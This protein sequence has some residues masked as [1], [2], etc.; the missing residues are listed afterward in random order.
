M[1]QEDFV[2]REHQKQVLDICKVQKRYG[3]FF[4]MGAGKTSTM[5]SLIDYL[6][7]ESME[8][9]KIL[10]IA[11]STVINKAKVW[12]KEIKKW[13]NFHFFDFIELNGSPDDRIKKKETSLN[14]I[15][16]MSDG[17]VSWYKNTYKNLDDFDMIIID[18]S[19]RFK[20]HKSEKFKALSRMV[21]DRHRVYLLSGTPMPNGYQD[22]WSQM[23]LLDGGKRMDDN[24]YRF[25]KK[26]AY[27]INDYKFVFLKDTKEYLGDK[28]SDICM[29]SD[30]SDIKLPE[31]EEHLIMLKWSDEKHN[32]YK[33]FR[34]HYVLELENG[35]LSV[36]SITALLN[37][38]LQL[39]N[40]CVYLDKELNYEVFDN[41]KLDWV[42]N[43]AK[44]ARDNMLVFYSFKFDKQRLLT[45]E[46][47]RE[48]KSDKDV[49]DWNEG[50]IK[51]GV[52]SPY[53]FQYGANLQYGGSIIV[54]F[55]L[56]WG[57][58]N[59]L[60]SNH[61]IWRY[62]Q[63]NKVDIYYLLMEDTNDLYVYKRV[64]A[65]DMEEQDFLDKIKLL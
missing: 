65:K 43:F 5:L 55:G 6:V 21:K 22:L 7:F 19:S 41:T 1:K 16:L 25:I 48:I 23:Y 12:Q 31:K 54:W 10:I 4:T 38:S 13:K 39:A 47:A 64:I 53:S 51:I 35:D 20:S 3:I 32:I 34:K 40:G 59:Y 44:T 26:Y 42:K 28:V 15:A 36:L 52:I 60:Q 9:E 45:I 37:K 61:R 56:L 8:V 24:Y 46:G 63:K 17:L 2:L 18:E 62:G 50:R 27:Y 11:P 49:D 57:L 29:F 58:E 33:N 14:T 30:G